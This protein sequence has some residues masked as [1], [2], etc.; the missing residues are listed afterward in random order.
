[1]REN[2]KNIGDNWDAARNVFELLEL[3]AGNHDA[4][5]KDIFLIF[6]RTREN[7]E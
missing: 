7:L 2:A 3:E 6:R 5:V 4:K 1:M